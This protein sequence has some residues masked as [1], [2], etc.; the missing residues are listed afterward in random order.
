MSVSCSIDY[1]GRKTD[2]SLAAETLFRLA[3]G[4]DQASWLILI[5]QTSFLLLQSVADSPQ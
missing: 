5:R 3:T 2:Y 4:P 1:D